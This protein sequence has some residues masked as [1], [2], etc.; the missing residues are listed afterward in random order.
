M[1]KHVCPNISIDACGDI[2]IGRHKYTH[3][4]IPIHKLTQMYPYM[5][6]HPQI[7]TNI[8][9]HTCNPGQAGERQEGVVNFAVA[10]FPYEQGWVGG[11]VDVPTQSERGE[12]LA[13]WKA[14]TH[15]DTLPEDLSTIMK[16]SGMKGEAVLKVC[17]SWVVPMTYSTGLCQ[18]YPKSSNMMRVF[19]D[20]NLKIIAE[21]S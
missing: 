5:H 8:P 19:A 12:V 7:D 6:T 20:I 1:G 11:W 3:I 17:R 18:E 10:W 4:C 16:W 9:T 14:D 2:S 15:T 13:K 21:T